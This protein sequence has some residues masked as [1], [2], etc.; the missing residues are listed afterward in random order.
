M[1]FGVLRDLENQIRHGSKK[2]YQSRSL[3]DLGTLGRLD[4]ESFLLFVYPNLL[5]SGS[6]YRLESGEMIFRQVLWFPLRYHVSVLSCD[7]ISLPLLLYFTFIVCYSCL[8]TKVVIGL[9]GLYEYI[10]SL[11]IYWLQTQ[12]QLQ[13]SLK[14]INMATYFKNLTIKLHILYI[15]KTHVKFHVNRILF[16]NFMYNFRLQKIEI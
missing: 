12:L 16:I 14:K 2:P 4:L 6:I 10:R 5:S 9:L 7:C 15:F 13:F 1:Q 11:R 3:E 8:C